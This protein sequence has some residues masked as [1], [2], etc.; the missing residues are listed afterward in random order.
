[1]ALIYIFKYPQPGQWPSTGSVREEDIAIAMSQFSFKIIR[2]LCYGRT[3]IRELDSG[4]SISDLRIRQVISTLAW[5]YR[6][7]ENETKHTKI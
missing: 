4:L 5:L 6:Y 2:D 1:M 7:R 3:W